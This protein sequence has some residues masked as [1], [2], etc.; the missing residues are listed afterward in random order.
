MCRVFVLDAATATG[1]VRFD[2]LSHLGEVVVR[3]NSAERLLRPNIT[4]AS[5]S[6]QWLYTPIYVC[7]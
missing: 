6:F 2:L 4:D 5:A 3:L 1:D 7:H